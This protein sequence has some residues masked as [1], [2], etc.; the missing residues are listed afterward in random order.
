M[1]TLQRIGI[2]FFLV[3]FLFG[4]SGISVFEHICT[5]K[6]R[7]E[8]TFFPEVFGHQSSCCCSQGEAELVTPDHAG[9]CGLENSNHC[10]NVKFFVKADVTPVPVVLGVFSF[11][12]D[13]TP[14]YPI[15]SG[16]TPVSEIPDDERLYCDC[17]S[18][19]ISGRQRVIA[20]HQSK[21][22]AHHLPLA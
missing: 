8:I 21:V 16:V 14:C 10:R 6:G 18:P 5:C 3:V 12:E 15:P 2:L 9:L 19:P 20:Y 7:T 22:P 1:K 11:G 13:I 4:T 17:T